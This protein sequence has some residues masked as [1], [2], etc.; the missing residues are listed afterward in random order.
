MKQSAKQ[1]SDERADDEG[2]AA[3]TTEALLLCTTHSYG[4]ADDSRSRPWPSCSSVVVGGIFLEFW[5]LG[6]WLE[7]RPL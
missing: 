2:Q 7:Q 5:L 6:K 3:L 4:T 1:S